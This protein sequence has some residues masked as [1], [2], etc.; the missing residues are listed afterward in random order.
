QGNLPGHVQEFLD[1]SW[2]GMSRRVRWTDKRRRAERARGRSPLSN[3]SSRRGG[4]RRVSKRGYVE[5]AGGVGSVPRFRGSEVDAKPAFSLHCRFIV[6]QPNREGKSRLY[7][8][9]SHRL[10][11]CLHELFRDLNT[12]LEL[13]AEGHDITAR[14]VGACKNMS[15]SASAGI[16]NAGG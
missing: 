9:S 6:K 13:S 3:S 16:R 14:S 2:S 15:E 5:G 10:S 12:R 1:G 8:S 7:R 11:I 4:M